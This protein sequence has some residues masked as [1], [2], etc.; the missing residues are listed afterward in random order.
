MESE[1]MKTEIIAINVLVVINL[2][3]LFK[4]MKYKILLNKAEI[5]MKQ[6][7]EK[8]SKIMGNKLIEEISSEIDRLKEK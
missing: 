2:F 1:K 3:L 8:M 6:M 5:V 4:V 7:T